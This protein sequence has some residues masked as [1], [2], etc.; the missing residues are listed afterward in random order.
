MTPVRRIEGDGNHD[1]PGEEN[2]LDGLVKDGEVLVRVREVAVEDRDLHP[3]RLT[4]HIVADTSQLQHH[5]LLGF[6]V[7]DI[8]TLDE[9]SGSHDPRVVWIVGH[10]KP[11]R[12]IDGLLLVKFVHGGD[13]ILLS[14]LHHVRAVEEGEGLEV[15]QPGLG[16]VLIDVDRVLQPTQEVLDSFQRGFIRIVDITSDDDAYREGFVPEQAVFHIN[17]LLHGGVVHDQLSLVKIDNH[18]A[19]AIEAD[20]E[21]AEVKEEDGDSDVGRPDGFSQN[22][23][24]HI[25]LLFILPPLLLLGLFDCVAGSPEA[26]ALLVLGQLLLWDMDQG[27]TTSVTLLGVTREGK[28]SSEEGAVE[29]EDHE[30]ADAGVKAEDLDV[31]IR[32]GY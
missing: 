27:D 20:S 25:L 1:D 7:S 32:G 3:T 17:K 29:D 11:V 19:D 9:K 13:K 18:V 6:C 15:L 10:V 26:E 5:V 16:Q 22:G 2:R 8:L 4:V 31:G 23:R 24:Q 30:E 21:V 14:L 12:R 28:A